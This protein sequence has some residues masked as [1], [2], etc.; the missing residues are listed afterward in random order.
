MRGEGLT[1]EQAARSREAHGSNALSRR[2]TRGFWH[3]FLSN[4]GDPIIRI[5]L[6]ALG[7]NVVLLFRQ[8]DWYESAGIALAVLVATLVSTLSE[9]GSEAAFAKIQEEAERTVCRGWRDGR[10]RELSVNEVVVG[11]HIHLQAGEGI[12]ADGKLVRGE[13]RV[14]QSAL[15]GESREVLCRAGA[16]GEGSA[17][18]RGAVVC[19]GEGVLLVERVGDATLYGRLAGEVQSETRESPLKL[20]LGKLA[21]QLSR[22]GYGAAVLVGLADLFHSLVMDNSFSLPAIAAACA[23]LP[24]LFGH[25]LHAVTLAITVVVVAVPEGLPMMITV[26]LSANMRRMLKDHVLVRKLVGVETS[27]SLTIL[28]TDK[29]GTLTRGEPEVCTVVTGDGSRFDGRESLKGHCPALWRHIARGCCDNNES[30]RSGERVLGGNATDR[31]L[32]RFGGRMGAAEGTHIPF[33]SARKWAATYLPEKGVWL[34][35]GAPEQL[36]SRCRWHLDERGE[37]RPLTDP[38]P[39]RRAL[40]EMTGRAM[41]VLALAECTTPVVAGE[42]LPELTLTALLGLRDDLRREAPEAVAALRQAGVQTVMVTGDNP[43]TA[44]AIARE[45]GLLL[46]GEEREGILT[47][48]ALQRLSDEQLAARLPT[49]RVVA[50]AV[51]TDKS[52]LVRVAQSR[53]LVVGMTGDG[54]NDAPAL[55]VADVGFAMGS[56]TAVAKEAGDIVILDDNIASIV[57]AVLYGRTIFKSIRKFLV[58]QLTMNLCAVGV[59]VIGPFIGVDTPVTVMQMLW[60]NLIMDTLAGLAFAGEPPL[61]E[62]LAEPPKSREEPVLTGDMLAQIGSMGLY[63]IGLCTVFLRHPVMRELFTAGARP[64][65]FLTGFFALFIFCGIANS[66]NARTPRLNLTAHLRQ[67]AAFVLIMLA[68]SGIQLLLMYFGGNLFR[69]APLTGSQLVRIGLLAATVWPADLLR[70]LIFSRRRKKKPCGQMR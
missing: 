42:A 69:T 62:Y 68:V 46:P 48:D 17:L 50:R 43:D 44:A 37:L 15:N 39:I 52:R 32:L 66:F 29:T 6:I 8:C 45:A 23:D 64:V 53:G 19:G 59:S 11:D 31:A 38:T 70:K 28:F 60:I 35:K 56:G 7:I 13:L 67:N 1:T 47:A 24:A 63:T 36:L 57:R 12:P 27:G 5:L 10:L 4:F 61:P 14:N 25:L 2:P 40:S 22:I 51:P 58:F 34:V 26:V 33:D 18:L 65:S 9:Q 41:R 54:V 21:K 16:T 3:R 20:R 30:R 55:K 49:L